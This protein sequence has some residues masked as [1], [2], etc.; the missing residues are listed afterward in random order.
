MEKVAERPTLILVMRPLVTDADNK[1]LRALLGTERVRGGAQ[2]RRLLREK[3]DVAAIVPFSR[4]PPSIVTMN[5]RVT[6]WDEKSMDRRELSLV[7]PWNAAPEL[8]RI[9]VLSVPGVQLL[10]AAPA[11]LVRIDGA[12]LRIYYVSYQPEASGHAHL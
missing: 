4:M 8:G 7:Y 2:A 11:Q 1:R 9:S 12:L 6:C 10:G 3:L 5:S